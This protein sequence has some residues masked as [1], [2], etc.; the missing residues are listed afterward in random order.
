QIN[1]NKTD[2]VGQTLQGVKIKLFSGVKSTLAAGVIRAW[3]F[4]LQPAFD[5]LGRYPRVNG[6]QLAANGDSRSPHF[7]QPSVDFD[8]RGAFPLHSSRRPQRPRGSELRAE[9]ARRASDGESSHYGTTTRGVRFVLFRAPFLASAKCERVRLCPRLTENVLF[10]VERDLYFLLFH[11][12][13]TCL[14]N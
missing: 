5:L 1:Q 13:D 10:K 14:Q 8:R 4:H 12:P 2:P 9:D 11:N 6:R 3:V 7:I